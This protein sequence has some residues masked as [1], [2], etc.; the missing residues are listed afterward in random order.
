M[1]IF[2]FLL[3]LCS[4]SKTLVILEKLKDQTEYSQF[5]SIVK[6]ENEQ[7]EIVDK[8]ENGI[9]ELRAKGPNVMLG[10]YE[11]EEQ[12][13][14]VLRDGWFYTGDLGYIDKEGYLF[15]TG[16]KKDMIV[17]KNGKKVLNFLYEHKIYLAY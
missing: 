17:L 16:R 15:L 8:D 7:V 6:Q 10:Y 11:N 14:E 2:F 4:A 1:K 13:N 12:T 9:G 5:L 3:T